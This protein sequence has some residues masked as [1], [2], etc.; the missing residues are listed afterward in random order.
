MQSD[1]KPF[2]LQKM[3]RSAKEIAEQSSAKE[4]AERV[5]LKERSAAITAA[6]V[7][8][9]K[10]A[11]ADQAASEGRATALRKE[12]EAAIRGSAEKMNSAVKE[13]LQFSNSRALEYKA[14]VTDS[15]RAAAASMTTMSKAAKGIADLATA[16]VRS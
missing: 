12:Q 15:D 8:A 6:I 1:V 9:S 11:C 10:Q 4:A 7:G 14:R 3:E 13:G 2:W 16:W 5:T